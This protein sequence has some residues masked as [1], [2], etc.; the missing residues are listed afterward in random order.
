MRSSYR[1]AN[2]PA[3]IVPLLA[4]LDILIPEF[5]LNPVLFTITFKL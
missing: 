5:I 3:S 4:L 2:L 1:L